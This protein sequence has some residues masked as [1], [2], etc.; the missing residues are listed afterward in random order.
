MRTSVEDEAVDL[1]R[2]L[3]RIDSVN[4][5]DPA[6]IGDGETRAARFVQAKLEE[7][8]IATT[9]VEP[10]PGRGSVVARMSGS[11]PDAEA[12]IVHAHLD[13]VPVDAENWTHPPFGAEIHDGMLY[14]R[15]AVDM[16]DFAGVILAIAR[17]LARTDALPRRDLI[18]A[19][20]A[21]EEA[22]GTWGAKWLVE[23]RPEL[24]AG[25]GDAISEVGGFSVPI[26]PDRR[27][28]LLATAEK[29]VGHVGLTAR[30]E[31][32][33]GS[34]PRPTD[35]VTRLAGAAARIGEHRFPVVRTRALDAF[36][37]VVGEA[38]GTEFTDDDLDAQLE[39]L[40]FTGRL[41]QA[42]ARQTAAP[43][44][45]RAGG[46]FNVIPA[47][48]HAELDVRA[49]PGG[50]DDLRAELTRLAGDDIDLDWDISISPISSPV[51]A[52]FVGTIS[53]ALVEED[54]DGVVV[55]YL[56]P[57]ST[58][59]KHFAKLGVRGYGFVPLRVPDDFDVYGQFHAADERVPVD[60]LR[61]AARTT[62]RILTTA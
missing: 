9:F 62:H 40:G 13:V 39:G 3:I 47:A 16:K 55:P 12:L 24:F 58:D 27:A 30:G 21:D 50:E 18:F 25:A 44:V 35:A 54:P 34:R 31:A 26:L 20:L 7:V 59:N 8:G 36:L 32:G 5:G 56:L 23:N 19:F 33:H 6:T 60:A 14:G 10:V 28:Y 38:R 2:E 57:A 15:G 17:D 49:L 1:V 41:I 4:T 29:G 52:E 51:D 22:G 37:R 53:R 48:A 42:S 46:K 11:D 43:T 61:F 45:L